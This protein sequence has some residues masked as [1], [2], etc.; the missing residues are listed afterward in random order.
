MQ[1]AFSYEFTQ[2]TWQDLITYRLQIM[3]GELTIVALLIKNAHCI[4][5][6]NLSNASAF[7]KTYRV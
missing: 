6:F 3:T 2:V 4:I 1:D 7:V 5:N